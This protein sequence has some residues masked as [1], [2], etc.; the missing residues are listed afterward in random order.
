MTM[1]EAIHPKNDVDRL[2]LKEAEAWSAENS[3]CSREKNSLDLFLMNSAEKLIREVC[4]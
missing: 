2:Y 1:Y 3:V 4:T